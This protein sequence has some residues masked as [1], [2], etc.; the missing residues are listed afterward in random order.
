[1]ENEAVI[2]AYGRG[3][4]TC[5]ATGFLASEHPVDFA[6]Q[7]LVGVLKK[8]PGIKPEIIT[9][10]IVGCARLEEKQG[11]NIGRIIAQ[12]SGLT[13]SVCGQ[14]VSRC[15]ASGLQAIVTASN[16]IAA[17]QAEV[18][19][20]GG[21]ESVSAVSGEYPE[22]HRCKWIEE[23]IPDLY[24][25]MGIAAENVACSY[26]ISRR[27]MD[28]FAAE[29][30]RKALAALENGFFSREIVPITTKDG[31]VHT[32]DERMQ[33]C[34]SLNAISKMEPCFLENGLVTAANSSRLSDGAAFVVMTSRRKAKELG[35]KPIAQLIGYSVGGVPAGI[36]GVGPMVAIPMVLAQT[37]LNANEMDVMELDEIFASQTLA[38]IEKL[39]L[40]ISRVN[41]RGGSIALGHPI[42]ADG[43]ILTCKALSYLKDSRGRYGLVSTCIGGGMGAAGIFEYL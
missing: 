21:V 32:L 39:T 22:E 30:H 28:W 42:G 23:N 16:S 12:R 43:A 18:L 37:K 25:S 41:P 17:G 29:S 15:D 3:P 31:T 36:M 34:T 38:C 40:D 33:P 11:Q 35:I 8:V 26:N 5:G 20:A 4:V 13:D 24:A 9:D 7:V 6:S 1:M 19:I 14:T 27:S 2:V 10:V